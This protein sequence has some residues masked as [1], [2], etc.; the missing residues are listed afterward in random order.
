MALEIDP[1]THTDNH[2]PYSV[3]TLKIFSEMPKWCGDQEREFRVFASSDTEKRLRF[4]P[5]AA[6]HR[7]FIHSLADDYGLD[8][9]SMDPEPHRHVAVFKTPRFVSAPSKT[10]RD[11]WRIRQSQLRE[12]GKELVTNAQAKAEAEAKAKALTNEPYNGYLL[13]QPRFALTEDEA[14]AALAGAQTNHTSTAVGPDSNLDFTVHFLPS[15]DVALLASFHVQ[16]KDGGNRL[17]GR[18]LADSKVAYSRGL[19]SQYKLGTSL[20]LARF[21]DSL[22]V[23]RREDLDDA[24]NAG[25]WSQVAAKAAAPR[26]APVVNGLGEKSG[27]AIL[28]TGGINPAAKKSKAKEKKDKKRERKGSLADDWEV[29]LEKEEAELEKAIL[30]QRSNGDGVAESPSGSENQS[31]DEESRQ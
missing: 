28:Q 27:F 20:L 18:T 10:L 5:M 15:E 22:N 6:H 31:E 9:E 11:A 29:E 19:I 13:T 7:V 4:K 1:A 16:P 26:R 8:S 12:E 17:L 14:L 2:I 24:T 23:L 30:G 21:D 25:G 3:E